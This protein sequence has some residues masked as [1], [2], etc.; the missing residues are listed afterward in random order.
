VDNKENKTI[1]QQIADM[2]LLTDDVET[3]MDGEL[4]VNC[5]DNV[6]EEDD[7]CIHQNLFFS[8]MNKSIV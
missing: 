4:E 2:V 7:D 3:V 8:S 1:Q 5:L 6:V